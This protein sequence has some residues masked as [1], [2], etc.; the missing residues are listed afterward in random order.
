MM[1]R[2]ESIVAKMTKGIEYLF[3]KNHVTWLKGHA[4]LVG[5]SAGG[6]QV[7]VSGDGQSEIGRAHV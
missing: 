7:E 2:K 5:K 4:T 6:W 1:A 3:K